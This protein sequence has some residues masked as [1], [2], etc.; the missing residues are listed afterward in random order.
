MFTENQSSV[1]LLSLLIGFLG[2]VLYEPFSLLR[3]FCRGKKSG[4]ALGILIDFLY[5]IVF[6][7]WC[8]F[9]AYA[10]YF[11]SFRV[12]MCIGYGFGGIIYLKTLRK[13]VAFFKKVCYN[14][15][16]K[17]V[18]NFKKARK[19]SPNREEEGI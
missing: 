16:R 7:S 19:N 2:G 10:F 14:Q 15:V 12:Y 18:S 4:Q 13:V 11:P 5:C 8:I 6:S 1:F 9:A 17:L 3:F